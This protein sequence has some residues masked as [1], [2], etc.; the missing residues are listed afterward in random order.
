[1]S[2]V[3]SEVRKTFTTKM[4]WALLIPVVLAALVINAF[5][6]VFESLITG[7]RD[8]IEF[9]SLLPMSLAWTLTQVSV[10]A[11]VYGAVATAGEFRFRTITTT[12]L[13]ASGRTAV[14]V[15][16]L[17][18]SALIGVVYGLAAAAAGSLVG[19]VA[20][21]A[22]P[23]AGQ[24]L[25]VVAIGAVVCALWA[26][27]GAG[28]GMAMGNQVGALVLLLVYLL[29]A[30]GV[31]SLVMRNVDNESVA[32][33]T[34]F[35]P[36]NAG[37]VAVLAIPALGLL[38]EVGVGEEILEGIAGVADPLSWGVALLVLALWTALVVGLAALFGNRRDI[39]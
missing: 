17:L 37:D 38:P 29:L 30:E 21:T 22:K 24:L 5:G 14:L 18:V 26:V 20:Q 15:A 25:A 1:M 6:G 9:P 28:L 10:L 23:D 13:T 34:S 11:A 32:A 36:G 7:G 33:L 35:L 12:Y 39:T 19:L 16:K 2:A 3:S 8:G 31:L 27:L 4:W